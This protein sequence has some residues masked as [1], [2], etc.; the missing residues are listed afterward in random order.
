MVEE[1]TEYESCIGVVE[2]I[3][4]STLEDFV[5]GEIS[6]TPV[7]HPNNWKQHWKGMPEFEQNDNPPFR[8][9]IISFRNQE[10]FDEFAEKLD[11]RVTDKTKSIWYPALDK[12]A[13][14]LLRWIE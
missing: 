14:S 12:E 3:D 4:S 1:S 2:K 6:A 10:D 5:E 7:G 11:Q 13:N 8:K 9:L